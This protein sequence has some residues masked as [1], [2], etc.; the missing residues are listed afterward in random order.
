M[1]QTII[2][3]STEQYSVLCIRNVSN[4]HQMKL[5]CMH[6][7]HPLPDTG[8]TVLGIEICG[9]PGLLLFSWDF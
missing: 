8:T 5:S 9:A 3:R 1:I 6:A 7:P 4:N 2:V